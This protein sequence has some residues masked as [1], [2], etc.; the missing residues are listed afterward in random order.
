MISVKETKLYDEVIKEINYNFGDVFVFDGFIISEVKEG[1]SFSWQ[2][3]AKS[4]TDD[5][6]EFTKTKGDE[7]I[8]ISHRIHSYSVV[9]TDWLKFFGKSFNLKGYGVVSNNNMSLVNIVVENLFFKKRIRRFS[10]IEAA[11]QWAKNYELV[12]SED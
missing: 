9:P 5:V 1:I 7:L 12:E 6:F 10:S 8:L 11:V 2:D 3:H 4:I